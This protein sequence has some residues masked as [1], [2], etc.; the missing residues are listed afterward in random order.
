MDRSTT[1]PPASRAAEP[2]S[3]PR[4]PRSDA[5]RQSRALKKGRGILGPNFQ[6]FIQATRNDFV[7][8]GL[9]AV[10]PDIKTGLLVD[11]VSALESTCVAHMRMLGAMSVYTQVLMH[12][13]D[14]D[15][16]WQGAPGTLSIAAAMGAD[17]PMLS[18]SE[19]RV[20]TV[21]VV[22]QDPIGHLHAAFVRY[23]KD[24]PAQGSRQA[25]LLEI[26]RRYW[27]ARGLSF[28]TYTEA[29]LPASWHAAL[30]WTLN[31]HNADADCSPR[32]LQYLRAADSRQPL[33]KILAEWGEPSRA[34][35]AFKK[36][37]ACGHIRVCIPARGVP[38]MF[39]PLP[40]RVLREAEREAA[41]LRFFGGG[42]A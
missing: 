13:E 17:H 24:L 21:D 22:V 15:P 9:S 35:A 7:S 11:S 26:A 10:I 8:R 33:R 14:D 40:F 1:N 18:R 41:L 29:D 4:S 2:R 20:M 30:Q 39:E 12:R 23:M 31:A 28:R 5:A 37:V 38:L 3:K 42:D 19:A 6:S 32:F 36:G 25:E 16:V 34:A 27:S